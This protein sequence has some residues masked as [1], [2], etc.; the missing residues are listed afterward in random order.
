MPEVTDN[1]SS[2]APKRPATRRIVCVE[3]GEVYDGAEAAARALG[4][5]YG[6]SNIRIAAGNGGMAKGYHWRFEDD[7]A[8]EPGEVRGNKAVVCWETGERFETAEA[9]AAWAGCTPK[10]IYAAVR[11]RN[12]ADDYHWYLADNPRPDASTLKFSKKVVCW[13]T[14]EV[15][16]SARSAAGSLGES[17][18][19]VRAA[20]NRGGTAGGL[21]WHYEGETP[22]VIEKV[23]AGKSRARSSAKATARPKRGVTCWETGEVFE[24]ADAAG[25]SVGVKR[26]A[27]ARA[28]RKQRRSGG[29]HWYWSDEPRP[30]SFEEPKKTSKPRPRKAV[31]CWETGEVFEN[32]DAAADAVGIQNPSCISNAIRKE[33]TCGG[34][35]W[36]WAGG[37][38]PEGFAPRERKRA[39]GRPKRAVVCWETGKIYPCAQDA[40]DAAGIKSQAT[41]C[42]AVRNHASAGGYHWY[43]QDESKPD[44]AELK[45]MRRPRKASTAGAEHVSTASEGVEAA[46]AASDVTD[47][48]GVAE[49]TP[50]EDSVTAT[51]SAEDEPRLEETPA[52]V[53]CSPEFVACVRWAELFNHIVDDFGRQCRG[54]AGVNAT[55]MRLLLGIAMF[56]GKLISHI[57]AALEIK[58]SVSGYSL[59]E[60]VDKGFAVRTSEKAG[61]PVELTPAGRSCLSAYPGL[62]AEAV[63]GRLGHMAASEK[64]ELLASIGSGA[65]YWSAAFRSW[66]ETSNGMLSDVAEGDDSVA[67]HGADTAAETGLVDV[68]VDFAALAAAAI[69]CMHVLIARKRD[70]AR[71][72]DLP[73][74]E[75]RALNILAAYPAPMRLPELCDRAGL[76]SNLGVKSISTLRKKELVT[77]AQSQTDH[78]VTEVSLSPTGLN[79]IE[80]TADGFVE[81]FERV[82]PGLALS[83]SVLSR[84]TN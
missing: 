41:I 27:I 68:D 61:T 56:P 65:A 6:G 59:N 8:T 25:A 20:I 36:Y 30:E 10:A 18:A 14:G 77:C 49:S 2:P 11:L 78:C 69:E 55:Q 24:N 21:H 22:A 44:A 23:I 58:R 3:T 1:S 47:D 17:V 79:L 71:S 9:A 51:D 42:A 64:R 26:D 15:F 35:H 80:H 52:A 72:V 66:L 73:P 57:A 34:C 82:F 48:G 81:A 63:D 31:V 29:F 53:D 40:A 39:G 75:M 60:L 62:V 16:L 13:E 7:E 4:I 84:N 38:R 19:K 54:R 45:S 33:G 50:N 70:R 37:P 67:V 46:E 76:D 32:A 28:I 83:D 74:S 43:Y 5:T 12:V